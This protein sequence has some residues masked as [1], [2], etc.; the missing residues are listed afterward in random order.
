[1]FDGVYWSPLGRSAMNMKAF[2]RVRLLTHVQGVPDFA[3]NVGDI[4]RR[5]GAG[6]GGLFVGCG[7]NAQGKFMRSEFYLCAVLK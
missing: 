7:E 1:M 3:A 4:I 2:E 5:L 6:A